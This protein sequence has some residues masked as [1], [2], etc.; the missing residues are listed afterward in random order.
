MNRILTS[1]LCATIMASLVGCN[2]S[3]EAKYKA[4]TYSAEVS[5]HNPG[6]KVTAEFS[7]NEL[8]KVTID[9]SNETESIGGKAATELEK[10]L[11][12]KQSAEIDG[13]SGA[14]ETSNA[15]KNAYKDILSQAQTNPETKEKKTL[16]DGQ[17]TET[18]A[19]FGVSGMMTGVVTIKDNK[20]TDIE[21]TE[22]HDSETAQWFNVAKEKLIPRILEAQSVGIDSIT[23]ATTSSGAIKNIVSRAI[24]SA[25]GD[26]SDWS[27]TPEKKTDT[28]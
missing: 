5:G 8:K 20:I 15:V 7:A 26:V 1:I 27:K 16:K 28:K 14:T 3:K 17:Y 23:G 10:Q 19:S 18:V 6:V 9:A 24:E 13:V 11:L 4:G 22:E 21:I 25:G 2:G 12:K